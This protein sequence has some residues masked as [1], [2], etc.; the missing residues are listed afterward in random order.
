MKEHHA[1]CVY[2][3]YIGGHILQRGNTDGGKMSFWFDDSKRH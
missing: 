3:Q 2:L 1:R